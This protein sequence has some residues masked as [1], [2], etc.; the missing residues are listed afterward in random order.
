[1]LKL[2]HPLDLDAVARFCRENRISRLAAFGSVL[3]DDFTDAS[4]IDLLVEFEP[5][6]RVGLLDL[7]RMELE[8]EALFGRRVDLNTRGF[9]SDYF[10]DEVM[11]EAVPIYVAA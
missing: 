10:A 4:D 8:L 6:A 9:L 1:M 11:R 5:G 7:A 3:R 2:S